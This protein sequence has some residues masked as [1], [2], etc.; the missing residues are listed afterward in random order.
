M[1]DNTQRERAPVRASIRVPGNAVKA[2]PCF[3]TPNRNRISERVASVNVEL[4][5]DVERL[6]RE[7]AHE[8]SCRAILWGTNNIV[9]SHIMA[10]RK[11][12]AA[13]TAVTADDL[14]ID[15]LSIVADV[16]SMT[17]GRN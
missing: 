13:G 9:A 2:E 1:I 14:D 15:K 6:E 3:L 16:G 5:R 7:L 11:Q 4:A 17:G 12:V 10:L 8:R